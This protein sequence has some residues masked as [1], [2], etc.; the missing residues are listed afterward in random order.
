[1][2][3]D[4]SPEYHE[5]MMESFVCVHS[6]ITQKASKTKHAGVMHRRKIGYDSYRYLDVLMTRRSSHADNQ[7]IPQGISPVRKFRSPSGCVA[8]GRL[9]YLLESVS[10]PH[11]SF[12]YNL[13]IV[14]RGHP[15]TQPKFEH[16]TA[17]RQSS[18]PDAPT[19]V[20]ENRRV[21][22]PDGQHANSRMPFEHAVNLSVR[23]QLFARPSGR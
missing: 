1:V 19:A 11:S 5:D 22:T 16:P 8:T 21:A 13:R 6:H 4:L 3:A 2:G 9:F 14:I 23:Q 17:S 12:I 10:L 15:A 7:H 20:C 18:A